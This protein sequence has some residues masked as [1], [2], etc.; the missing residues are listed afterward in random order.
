MLLV[1]CGVVVVVE[2]GVGECVLFFD[3]FYIVVGVSIGDVWVV[4]VVVK[5]VLLMVVEVGWLCGG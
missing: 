2:V 3:E 1:N 4:D 5:V